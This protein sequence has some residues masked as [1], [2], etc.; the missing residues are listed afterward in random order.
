MVTVAGGLGFHNIFSQHAEMTT[1]T[2]SKKK[3]ESYSDSEWNRAREHHD[4]SE[5]HICGEG[6]EGINS[7]K[8]KDSKKLCM[9]KERKQERCK[10]QKQTEQQECMFYKK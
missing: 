3:Y 9:L 1:L 8:H 4:F 10:I 6:T 5:L 7:L 2:L